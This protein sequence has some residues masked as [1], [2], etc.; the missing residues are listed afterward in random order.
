MSF[1]D[2]RVDADP[3]TGEFDLVLAANGDLATVDDLSTALLVSLLT[4]ARASP[5]QVVT[6]ELRRGWICN[7]SPPVEG[8]ELGSLL[9]L[10]EPS[11]ATQRT[12]NIAAGYARSA[13]QWMIDQKLASTIDVGGRITGAGA[14]ELEIVITAQDGTIERHVLDLW[15]RTTFAHKGLPAPIVDIPPFTPAVVPGLVMWGDADFSEHDVDSSVGVVTL[16]DLAGTADFSQVTASRR[17]LRLLGSGGWFWRFDGI[18]DFLTTANIVIQNLNTGTLFFVLRP[19]GSITAGDRLFSLGFNGLA[20]AV[21]GI[22]LRQQ[23]GDVLRLA[24]DNGELQVDIQGNANDAPSIGVVFRWG[25]AAKGADASTTTLLASNDPAYLVDIGAPNQA[26]VG[27]GYDGAAVDTGTAAAFDGKLFSLW[28]R[29]V[30]DVDLARL[31]DY[32]LARS[33]TSP[34]GEHFADGT[35]FSDDI[36]WS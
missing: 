22:T 1:V 23:A 36:G 16:Q 19:A 5:D 3:S 15:E 2:L 35:F 30:S 21:K 11:K 33:F 26:V 32:G 10:T 4:D 6:P 20:D 34:T 27:A 25:N 18:D 12:M 14:G 28:D 9:W 17:P 7:V 29:R 24:G 13:L 31:L 8:F